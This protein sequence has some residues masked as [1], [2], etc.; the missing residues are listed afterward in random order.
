MKKSLVY[1]KDKA[2]RHIK[3]LIVDKD[4]EI[5]LL[6]EQLKEL[7]L[8]KDGLQ[9]LLDISESDTVTTFE[10]G[11]YVNGIREIYIKLLGMNV[12]QNN[13]RPVIESVL[14]QFTNI[15]LEGPLPSA[16]TTGNLFTE[17]QILAKI[18]A[19]MAV[20]ENE[21]STLHYDETSKYGRKAGSIQVTAGGR[22][23]AVGLFD[24]DIGTAERLFDSIKNCLE[25]TAVHLTKVKKT[26]QLPKMLLNLKNT[27][28]DRHSVNDCVDDLLEQWKTEIAKVTIDGFN[29]IDENEQK[30]F[31]SINR[32]RCSLHFLLGL[33]DA[34]EKGL[35]EY[36]KIVRN[37][38]LVSNCRIVKSGESNTTRTIRTICKAFQKH[39]SEQA[40]AM[41][42]FAIHLRNSPVK[43]TTFRGNRFNVLFWNAA[44]VIYHQQHFNSFFE[45]YGTPNN[46]LR[47]VREDLDEIENIAGCRALGI[48]DKLV[49]GPY[50]RKCE[51]VENILDLNPVIEEMQRNCLQWSEDSSTLLF[52]QKPDF[53]MLIFTKIICM[54]HCFK[55]KMINLI[56]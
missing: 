31:T 25:K 21:N 6:Q 35:L 4:D 34:A 13:V 55:S 45:V 14:E 18:Q 41:A 42:P 40:G 36:D 28:T 51:A 29:E 23:Y 30:I 16:A 46:L 27:M 54:M 17:A 47:A 32:L 19:A 1:Y 22:S 43:L 38:P 11:R 50:W 26:D 20:A 37:G 48:I 12:G 44:C 15:R 52:D 8:E 24:E 5:E 56:D 3:D 49:I 2:S 33:A 53:Q 39:G 10:S 7:K 9:A